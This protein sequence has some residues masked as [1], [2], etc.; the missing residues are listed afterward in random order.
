MLAARVKRTR[1]IL[2]AA[3]I[4]LITSICFEALELYFCFLQSFIY[5]V[6]L[7][8][9]SSERPWQLSTPW[10]LLLLSH[11]NKLNNNANTLR[12]VPT[13]GVSN[14]LLL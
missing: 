9:R 13:P 12:R 11:K 10:K 3:L 2:I 1:S 14:D 4:E 6:L 7:F 8:S 5:L